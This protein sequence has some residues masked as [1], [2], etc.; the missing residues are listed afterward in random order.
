[1]PEG[2]ASKQWYWRRDGQ[3]HGPVSWAALVDLAGNETLQPSDEVWTPGRLG[4]SFASETPGLFTPPDEEESEPLASAR[5]ATADRSKAAPR[6][7]RTAPGTGL[8]ERLGPRPRDRERSLR[9]WLTAMP[10]VPWWSLLGIFV[11]HLV[12]SIWFV[13]LDT[14]HPLQGEARWQTLAVVLSIPMTWLF[15]LPFPLLARS[16][17]NTRPGWASAFIACSLN[18]FLVCLG[19]A[20]VANLVLGDV[21]PPSLSAFVLFPFWATWVLLREGWG[22]AP[23]Q[24]KPRPREE[25]QEA[26]VADN[27]AEP[28]DPTDRTVRSCLIFALAVMVLGFLALSI[29][30]L[31]RA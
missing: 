2:N 14:W 18:C 7:P 26:A 24:P 6:S 1:M 27:T 29:F 22:E 13:F 3:K 17:I 20:I 10:P 12:G 28:L 4:W 8:A 30:A 21:G 15:L 31:V 9:A 19:F 5:T 23:T 16:T 11:V 25:V